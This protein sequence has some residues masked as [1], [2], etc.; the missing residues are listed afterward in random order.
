M[1]KATDK[2]LGELHSKLAKV[3]LDALSASDEATILLDEFGDEL[4]APLIVFLSKARDANP[5]LL[6]AVTKFLKDN[7]ITC[8][9]DDSNEMSELE[10]LIRKKQHARKRIG[11]V[12][13]IEE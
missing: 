7:A 12:V 11:N 3:M 8:S 4:P 13:P 5:A 9:I 10:N 6:S 1:A 2:T